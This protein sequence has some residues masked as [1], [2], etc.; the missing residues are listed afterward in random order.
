MIDLRLPIPAYD[1]VLKASHAFNVMDA[2]GSV[3]VSERQKLFAEMRNLTRRVSEL[4]IERRKELGWP[5]L[6]RQD[7]ED[8]TKNA[9][10][11]KSGTVNDVVKKNDNSDKVDLDGKADFVLEIGSEELPADY[12]SDGITQLSSSF[13]ALLASL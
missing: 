5:L 7:D 3:G 9:K 8:E 4:W 10:S 13:P 12:V 1:H 2:R 11:S 6:N